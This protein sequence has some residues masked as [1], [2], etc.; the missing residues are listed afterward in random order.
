MKRAR[1]ARVGSHAMKYLLL[2]SVLSSAASAH[3]TA[4]EQTAPQEDRIRFSAS[5]ETVTLDVFVVDDRGR[6]VSNLKAEDFE[7][8]EDGVPQELSFFTAQFTPVST[9]LLLD[10]SS[11]IRSNASAIQTAAYLFVRNMSEGDLARVGLFS[12]DVRFGS[13]FTDNLEEHFGILRSMSPA[14]KTAL[15]DAVIAALNEL[16]HV[17]GRKSLL[18]FTDG[19]DAGPAQQGSA[20][21]AEDA[22]EKGKLSEVTIY[23]VGFTGFGAD[24]AES[25][26]RPFLTTLAESTGG[27]AFFPKDVEAVQAA[28]NEVREDLHRHYRI[29]YV[30]MHRAEPLPAGADPAQTE[31]EAGSWRQIAVRVNGRDD[32]VIRTRQGYYAKPESSP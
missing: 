13:R 21:T 31:T 20:S 23:T 12:N 2:L 17:E 18:V 3:A 30:P 22:V 19:D 8:L 10:S 28:F 14:G 6:F 16:A 9:L 26:N 4:D 1:M 15:Y 32:L 29:A 24:G 27:R 5:V 25:V 11:S 7:V